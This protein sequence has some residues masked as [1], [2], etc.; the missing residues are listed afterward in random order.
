MWLTP[1]F[2]L[3]QDSF[4]PLEARTLNAKFDACDGANAK[5]VTLQEAMAKAQKAI[6]EAK[7]AL[8]KS[9]ASNKTL[10]KVL[11]NTDNAYKEQVAANEALKVENEDDL[12]KE[13]KKGTVKG[14]SWGFGGGAFGVI[15]GGMAVFFANK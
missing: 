13:K 7:V 12:K 15:L 3:A 10:K 14:L 8:E 11:K 4:T 5:I 2:T 6:A 9:E 1:N